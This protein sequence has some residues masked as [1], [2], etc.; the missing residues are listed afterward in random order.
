MRP[1]QGVRWHPGHQQGRIQHHIH[2]VERE[3]PSRKAEGRTS[4][5]GQ[6]LGRGHSC[7]G[8]A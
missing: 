8:G 6:G 3:V 1:D 2:Q 5:P 7:F 4:R